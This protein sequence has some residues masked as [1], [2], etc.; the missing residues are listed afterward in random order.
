MKKNILTW[1][2]ERVIPTSLLLEI[3]KREHKIK[4]RENMFKVLKD[5][6][7]I[8]SVAGQADLEKNIFISTR[9][10]ER[11]VRQ[12]IDGTLS[13]ILNRDENVSAGK[14][15]FTGNVSIIDYWPQ[16]KFSI[17]QGIKIHFNDPIFSLNFIDKIYADC[18]IYYPDD[19]ETDSKEVPFIDLPPR[20]LLTEFRLVF[21]ID[22]H[23]LRQLNQTF[24]IKKGTG[25]SNIVFTEL[26]HFKDYGKELENI[27]LIMNDEIFKTF[28]DT[29]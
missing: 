1:F 23:R 13:L 10:N 22:I 18:K 12:N 5:I 4:K 26:P 28:I 29:F 25:I 9:E 11:L 17:P 2:A 16:M 7:E 24:M 3:N 19:K 15:A 27:Y 14:S 20:I 6:D 21:H 8:Q